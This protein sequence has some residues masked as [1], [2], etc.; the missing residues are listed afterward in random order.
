MIAYVMAAMMLVQSPPQQFNLV[1][2]G[3]TYVTRE[4]GEQTS[5]PFE[6]TYRFDLRRG[7][8]CTGNCSVV[9]EIIDVSPTLLVIEQRG[10]GRGISDVSINRTTGRYRAN[11]DFEAS[12]TNVLSVA[13]CERKPFTGI[14]Q[15]RF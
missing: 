14:P 8:W 11:A 7:A 3:A 12:R 1:C 13:H 5:T 15:A 6:Q 9:E 2:T 4:R 10:F